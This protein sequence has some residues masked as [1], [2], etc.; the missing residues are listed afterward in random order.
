[1]V[2]R[3]LFGS[4]L[5]VRLGF[6]SRKYLDSYVS[7]NPLKENYNLLHVLENNNVDVVH[8]SRCVAHSLRAYNIAREREKERENFNLFVYTTTTTTTTTT[9]L[10]LLLH[11]LYMHYKGREGYRGGRRRAAAAV[12]VAIAYTTRLCHGGEVTCKEGQTV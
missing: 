12:V 7:V 3:A 6:F 2:G 10:L 8:A 9:T 4:I 11:T 5:K 1:M